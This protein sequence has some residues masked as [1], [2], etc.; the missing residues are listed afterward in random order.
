MHSS[1]RKPARP[2]PSPQMDH[3]HYMSSPDFMHRLP[4]FPGA[5]SS[6]E[7]MSLF[8]NAPTSPLQPKH[9]RKQ[10]FETDV[11]P[12]PAGYSLQPD[13]LKLP[14]IDQP[15]NVPNYKDSLAEYALR[16]AGLLFDSSATE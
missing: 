3:R 12:P 5:P 1:K 10:R 11:L 15:S 2:F 4:P 7:D 13:L 14:P 8:Y 6:P 16:L 9:L